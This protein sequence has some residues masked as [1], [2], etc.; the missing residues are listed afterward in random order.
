AVRSNALALEPATHHHTWFHYLDNIQDWCV[1]R[2]LWWGH[3]IPAYRVHLAG[4]Q[5]SD[6]NDDNLENERWVVARNEVEARQLA[7][8]TYGD[9]PLLTLEQDQDVLDTWFSSALLP[10]SA[11]V[12]AHSSSESMKDHW[13]KD[14]EESRQCNLDPK[15]LVRAEKDLKREFPSGIPSCGT[16]ALRLTLSTY[17]AQALDSQS[18]GTADAVSKSHEGFESFRLAQSAGAAQR[19][20]LQD[21]CDV[22]IEF[23]KPV[24]YSAKNNVRKTQI[25]TKMRPK[26]FKFDAIFMQIELIVVEVV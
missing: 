7:V 10:L 9:H 23:S 6:D 14:V 4:H 11:L 15:E 25:A 16:D 12:G 3:R 1:S 20:F 21:L 24:L 22:Y 2:Q 5:A 17:L 26:H 18:H 13:A 8:E 19:F